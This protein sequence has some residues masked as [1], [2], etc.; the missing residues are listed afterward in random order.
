MPK[1]RPEQ[2]LVLSTPEEEEEESA[3]Q[4][5]VRTNSAGMIQCKALQPA[6]SG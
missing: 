4:H 6:V 5:I 3:D 1:T 2:D